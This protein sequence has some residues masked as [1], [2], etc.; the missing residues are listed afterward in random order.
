MGVVSWLV[1]MAK[2]LCRVGVALWWVGVVLDSLEDVDH[3]ETC[4]WSNDW[5]G[6]RPGTVRG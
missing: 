1:G 5:R 6:P 3:S 2:T 4:T